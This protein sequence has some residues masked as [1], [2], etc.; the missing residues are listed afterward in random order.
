MKKIPDHIQ[1]VYF[2]GIA[3]IGMTGE[4][5]HRK[6]LPRKDRPKEEKMNGGTIRNSAKTG[7]KQTPG[8]VLR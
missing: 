3:G 4:K 5:H 7:R 6:I 1:N 2:I 8:G